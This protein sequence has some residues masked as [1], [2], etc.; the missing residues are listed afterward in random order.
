MPGDNLS[1]FTP[2]TVA[3]PSYTAQSLENALASP[4][5]PGYTFLGQL[6]RN[7][8]TSL[9]GGLVDVLGISQHNRDIKA[10][11]GNTT[12]AVLEALGAAIVSGQ[13]QFLNAA[14]NSGDAGASVKAGV[15]SEYVKKYFPWLLLGVGGLTTLLVLAFRRR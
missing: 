11:G 1:G 2:I 10:N 5:T 9:S 13:N 6:W 3:T 12:S 4:A 14:G 7:A 15:L 8:A